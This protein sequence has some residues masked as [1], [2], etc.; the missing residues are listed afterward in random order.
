MRKKK[1][2][3]TRKKPMHMRSKRNAPQ[4]KNNVAVGPLL[5][6][7]YERDGEKFLHKFTKDRPMLTCSMDGTKM[8]LEGGKYLWTPLGVK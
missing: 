3:V 6:I 2:S 1:K 7:A 5:A 8:F 4:R